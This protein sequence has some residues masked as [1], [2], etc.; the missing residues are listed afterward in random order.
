[1]S[2]Q[3]GIN[4]RP[5]WSFAALSVRGLIVLVLVIAAG[6]SWIANRASSQRNAVGAIE[7]AGGKVWYDFELE[8]TPIVRA[9]PHA[10]PN[11]NQRWTQWL[12]SSWSERR[13]SV[14]NLLQAS[15]P[16]W[17]V[18][19]L[20]VD[21]FSNVVSVSFTRR[22]TDA[23]LF[24][25]PKLQRVERLDLYGSAVTEA[26]L[27]HLKGLPHLQT[28]RLVRTK[29]CDAGLAQ[30]AGLNKLKVLSLE[31]TELSDAG[32]AHLREL[33]NLEDLDLA[34]TAVSDQG[35]AHLQG[36]TK[37]R[38]LDLSRTGI[39][40]AG[41]AYIEGLSNLQELSLG[42]TRVTD[43]GLAHLKRLGNLVELTLDRTAVSDAGL[44]QIERLNQ[45]ANL[46][47]DHT[48]VTDAAS[49]SFSSIVRTSKRNRPRPSG[50]AYNGLT[51][52]FPSW[53]SCVEFDAKRRFLKP[54]AAQTGML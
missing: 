4:S 10:I 6:L 15:P 17:L 33:T 39:T 47:L 5:W 16:T 28:V 53:R 46:S 11:D 42:H 23:A 34:S 52:R 27:L 51:Q 26:G 22:A 25:V 24:H 49:H 19:S 35:L 8:A 21:Y 37:L 18:D 43:V 29:V 48:K 36:L 1:M 14:V 20:G 13:Q 45:L 9:R 54:R 40:D 30:L 31:G 2:K 50:A 41:L 3:T 32:R 12:A 7:K 38:A 44:S